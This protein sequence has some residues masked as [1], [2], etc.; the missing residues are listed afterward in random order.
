MLGVPFYIHAAIF[1]LFR[2]V[3]I[4]FI[5]VIHGLDISVFEFIFVGIEI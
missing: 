2:L 3:G 4:G 1:F 5:F